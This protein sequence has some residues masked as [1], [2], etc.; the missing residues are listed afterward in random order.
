MV[1]NITDCKCDEWLKLHTNRGPTIFKQ[2]AKLRLLVLNVH[3]NKAAM[4]TII[5]FQMCVISTGSELFL[6]LIWESTLTSSYQLAELSVANMLTQICFILTQMLIHLLLLIG[7]NLNIELLSIQIFKL[8][9]IGNM[10][11][12]IKIQKWLITQE[13]CKKL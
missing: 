5:S 8:L 6:T 7:L 10:F 4:A 3:F 11:I 13:I 9:Q 12:H 2:M 1:N